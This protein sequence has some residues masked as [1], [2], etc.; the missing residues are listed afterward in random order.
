[1]Y[2]KWISKVK[3]HSCSHYKFLDN[4][5]CAS[6]FILRLLFVCNITSSNG[7]NIYIAKQFF[8]NHN[9]RIPMQIFLCESTVLNKNMINFYLI[10]IRIIELYGILIKLSDFMWS[11]QMLEFVIVVLVYKVHIFICFYIYFYI[12]CIFAFYFV[13][14]C[15]T[16]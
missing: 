13:E 6:L 5:D 16:I 9:F 1:M 10:E 4:N 11:L 7:L 15:S 12:L 2:T 14:N 3:T 8:S